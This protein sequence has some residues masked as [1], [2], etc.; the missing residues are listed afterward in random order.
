MNYAD[1][2]IG[3]CRNEGGNARDHGLLLPTREKSQQWLH[4]FGSL[5]AGLP[6]G[7]AW[8]FGLHRWGLTSRWYARTRGLGQGGWAGTQ[9]HHWAVP[10]G[11]FEGTGGELIFNQPWNPMPQDFPP[12]WPF[13]IGQHGATGSSMALLAGSWGSC[14]RPTAGLAWPSNV[15]HVPLGLSVDPAQSDVLV[16]TTNAP[17]PTQVRSSARQREIQWAEIAHNCLR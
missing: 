8:K 17:T 5:R 6:A 13:A 14:T 3:R 11:W 16:A 10:L 2:V 9:I 7:P 4:W 1:A 15:D 12:T